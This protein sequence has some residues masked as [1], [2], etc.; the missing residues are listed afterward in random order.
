MKSHWF[1]FYGQDW[2][3]DLKIIKLNPIDRLCYLSLL[4]LASTTDD[5]IITNCDENSLIELTHL[6]NNPFD[7][8]DNE[9]NKAKGCIKRYLDNKMITLDDN[10]NITIINFK[11]R[12]GECL[13]GYE[14]VKKF[15]ENQK[16][17]LNFEPSVINDNTEI[18]PLITS[19]KRREEKRREDNSINI[20]CSSLMN[21]VDFNTF[22]TA[23]PKHKAKDKAKHGFLKLN[24]DLLPTILKAIV[25]QKKTDQWRKDNGQF[26]PLPSTWINQK[27]WEDEINSSEKIT[28]IQYFKRLWI[29]LSSASLNM[30]VMARKSLCQDFILNTAMKN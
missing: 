6:Y 16:N 18:T 14:R 10:N 9:V 30:V 4:C 21:E 25:E 29:W 5:G 11:R 22:Y 15:R 8:E 7:D 2:L 17:K 1:K 13:T 19:D 12:Q 23:Y 28:L 24:K 3:T 27:R 26:I 20:S